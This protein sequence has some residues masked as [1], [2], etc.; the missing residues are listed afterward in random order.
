MTTLT[1]AIKTFL[2]IPSRLKGMFCNSRLVKNLKE[3]NYFVKQ[4]LYHQ[5]TLSKH[6][7]ETKYYKIA[8]AYIIAQ[9][10]GY[11]AI[12][13]AFFHFESG[14]AMFLIAFILGS[15]VSYD[16]F[17]NPDKYYKDPIY[18]GWDSV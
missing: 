9:V 14:V 16:A 13:I 10:L 2:N 8:V 4:S 12:P 1:S 5:I 17:R 7:W 3:I 15:T 6:L 18:D 11:L